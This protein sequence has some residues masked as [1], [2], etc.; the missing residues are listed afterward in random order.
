MKAVPASCD[1]CGFAIYPPQDE[2]KQLDLRYH[3]YS[4]LISLRAR[5][6]VC[7]NESCRRHYA[8]VAVERTPDRG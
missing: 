7:P 8:Y 3:S 2:A 1:D 6:V 4:P 5:V